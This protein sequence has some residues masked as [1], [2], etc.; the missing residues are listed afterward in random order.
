MGESAVARSGE[1]VNN[2]GMPNTTTFDPVLAE[3]GLRYLTKRQKENHP[4]AQVQTLRRIA[5]RAMAKADHLEQ[6]NLVHGEGSIC[7][8]DPSVIDDL[9]NRAKIAGEAMKCL[10]V[11]HELGY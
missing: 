8:T 9:H 4:R 5:V 11:V 6:L 10:N 3:A 2:G 7:W 1:H